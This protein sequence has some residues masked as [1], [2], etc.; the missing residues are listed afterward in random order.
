MKRLV[1]SPQQLF[2]AV[3]AVFLLA[4][5]CLSIWTAVDPP[6]ETPEYSLTEEKTLLNETVVKVGYYCSSKSTPWRFVAVSWNVL[7]LI[8]ATVL[9][10]Q[11]RNLRQAFNE[12]VVL[13]NLI[14]SHFVF[15]LLRVGSFFFTPSFDEATL[16]LCQ[17]IIFSTDTFF[18]LLIYFVPKF[19][20][21]DDYPDNAPL[22]PISSVLRSSLVLFGGSQ[23]SEA[24]EQ[25]EVGL[26]PAATNESVGGYK[27]SLP[28]GENTEDNDMNNGMWNIGVD[29]GRDA[30]KTAICEV[31]GDGNAIPRS[32]QLGNCEAIDDDRGPQ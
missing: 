2:G 17:S 29:R 31:I 7:L 25:T 18:T 6:T 10:F 23:Q 20:A 14:Y 16:A 27:H 15:V 5:L 9:A 8:C 24:E 12:T 32:E 4:C 13:G 19:Q 1:I 22:T 3:I 21:D 30:I 11:T 28:D 26:A